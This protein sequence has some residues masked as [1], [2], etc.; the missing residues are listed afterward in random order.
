MSLVFGCHLLRISCCLLLLVL[1]GFYA[2]Q[3]LWQVRYELISISGEEVAIWCSCLRFRCYLW[4]VVSFQKMLLASISANS[5]P[6]IERIPWIPRSPRNPQNQQ[7]QW[8]SAFHG[9]A[10]VNGICGNLRNPWHPQ[11]PWIIVHPCIPF[12]AFDRFHGFHGF[13]G[14]PRK[15]LIILIGTDAALIQSSWI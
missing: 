4:P 11:M 14:F 3:L 5:R 15:L 10:S 2:L 13:H 8:I 7:T 1:V 9:I 6:W 12:H